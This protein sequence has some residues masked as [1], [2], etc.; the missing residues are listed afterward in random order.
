LH[1]P[2]GWRSLTDAAQL[3]IATK[4]DVDNAAAQL[5]AKIEAMV[6]RFEAVL[7]KHTAGI[8]LNFIV[9]GGLLIWLF[10]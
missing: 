10:R 1:T 5:D 4:A 9:I 7:W 6:K 8:I 3:G 2:Q